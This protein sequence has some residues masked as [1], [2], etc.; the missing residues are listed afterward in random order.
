MYVMLGSGVMPYFRVRSA[1]AAPNFAPGPAWRTPIATHSALMSAA[2]LSPEA[3]PE[4][5]PGLP[6]ELSVLDDPVE[7]RRFTRFELAADGRSVG[8]SSFQLSGMH[9]AAC[10]DL[11]EGALVRVPGVLSARVSAAAQR[12]QV[13]W[14]A[15]QARPSALVQAVRA[16]GYD[17]VPDAAA[18]ARALRQRERRTA[19][20]RLFVASFCMMQVMMFATP[21]YVAG[22]GELAPDLQQLLNW[23]SWLLSLPVM[24]FSAWP[25]LAGAWRSLAAR[26]VGM[27]VPVALGLVV[28]FVASSGATFAPDSLFGRETYFDSLTMF[29]SFLL[30]GRFLEMAARHKAAESLESALSAMPETA[31]RVLDDGRCETVSVQ[32]LVPGDRV[33][34]LLGQAV[35]ADGPIEHG[36]THVDESLLTGESAAVA[37]GP[38]DLLVA[39]SLNQGGVVTMRVERVGAD[40][41][42][43]AIVAMVRDAMSQ[44]PALA[45]AADRWAGP[46]LVAVLLLAVIAAGAWS[47]IDPSRAV[48]VF[49]SVLIVTC[50]CALSL[51]APAALLAA[52]GQLARRGVLVKR[53]DALDALARVQTLFVDKTGTLTEDAARLQAT[54]AL[55]DAPAA[56]PADV[57]AAAAARLAAQSTHPLSRV[58]A[59]AGGRTGRGGADTGPAADADTGGRTGGA[60]AEPDA[61]AVAAERL[62][63]TWQTVEELPGLGIQA[64]DGQGRLW[65]LGRADWVGA[66]VEAASDG[67]A[68]WFGPDGQAWLRFDFDE[69]L[70]PDAALALDALR[71]QGLQ[72]G[73]LSG[74]SPARVARLAARL[75]LARAQGGATPEDKLAAVVAEQARGRR[76]AMIGDGV[77]DAPVLARADVSFA[78]GHG[79][80]VSRT[81]AD[82]VIASNRL[83]DV[84]VAQLLARR[85]MRVVRQNFLW[86]AV[87][88]LVSIPLA[89]SGHLPP[90]GAGLGMAMS[91]LFVIGNAARL[92]RPAGPSG[93]VTVPTSST[94][95]P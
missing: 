30:L 40:T 44:R 65:R 2:I 13:R 39:G 20:W 37:R 91:S 75:G 38:G 45:A 1:H 49:V 88:N 29:L 11:I 58:I 63:G 32:R 52:A 5:A 94:R 54:V 24:V 19:L 12:A 93:A 7:Q 84:V 83:G 35:P 4:L 89:L 33:R 78:M 25:F 43:E 90:W 23:G 53:L 87:Y 3:G 50:P 81:H 41:R 56:V 66:G 18:P 42:F 22:A 64:R 62:V 8:E 14:D 57:L 21:S 59:Q 92:A 82:A 51:A 61:A 36:R 85:T 95:T 70:R 34:V 72:V 10:A 69:Q 47:F 6:P 16:A 73:L 60:A 27:D 80:L 79:A 77:N 28:T 46:F 67:P 9:C 74:D 71:R 55:A 48:W 17:A 31:E 76:V 15:G 86:A 26:R 68:T